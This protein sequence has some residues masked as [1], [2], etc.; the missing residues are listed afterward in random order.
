M[1]IHK[2]EAEKIL[3]DLGLSLCS[4]LKG[5]YDFLFD[6]L[7]EDDWSFIIKAHALIEAAVTEMIIQHIGQ[8][9]LKSTI[10]LLPLSDTKI[11]KIAI[12]KQLGLVTPEERKFVRWFSE[13]RNLLVHRV[14]NVNFSFEIYLTTLDSNQKDSWKKSIIWFNKDDPSYKQMQLLSVEKPKVAVFIALYLFISFCS[15]SAN[16]SKGFRLIDE[17]AEKTVANLLAKKF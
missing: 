11:G 8:E 17:A 7:K 9:S 14:E 16:T 12:A 10:E 5:K 3:V 6:L 1:Y 13:L 4:E 15:I 2:K